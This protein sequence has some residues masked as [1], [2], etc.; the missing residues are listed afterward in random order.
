MK[1]VLCTGGFDPLHSGHIAYFNEAKKLGDVLVVGV[2]SDDWLIR[3]KGEFFLSFSERSC[4]VSNLRVVDQV[5]DFDDKDDTAIDAIKRTLSLYPQA[6][7][8]FANGGDR[9]SMNIPEMQNFYD[10]NVTFMF[11]VGGSDK[12][13]SSRWILDRWKNN[14]LSKSI[15]AT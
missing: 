9:T 4:I 13:N 2:N 10:G 15:G 7:I 3:K 5:I 11:G 6:E 12:K 14:E 8:L 1:V